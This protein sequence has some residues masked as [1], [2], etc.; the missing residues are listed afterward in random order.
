MY[1]ELFGA[2]LGAGDVR[3]ALERF[4]SSPR[5]RSVVDARAG[6]LL[7]ADAV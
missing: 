7:P 5:G 1:G 3:Q 4:P 2:N 6:R